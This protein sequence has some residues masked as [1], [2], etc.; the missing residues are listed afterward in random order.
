MAGCGKQRPQ[1]SPFEPR[2]EPYVP[3]ETQL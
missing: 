2:Y 1:G 3:R